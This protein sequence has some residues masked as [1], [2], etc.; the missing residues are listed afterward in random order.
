[1]CGSSLGRLSRSG[2]VPG[3]ILLAP[4]ELKLYRVLTCFHPPQGASVRLVKYFL[5]V[6][7]AGLAATAC[8]DPTGAPSRLSPHSASLVK[9][10]HRPT[11]YP[12]SRK[13]RDA[14]FRPATGSAGSA[15][16]SVRSMLGRSG[17]T[18]VEVTTG[19]F[20]A[21]A[22]GTLS[23]VQVKGYDPRGVQLFTSTNNGLTVSTASFPYSNL[24]RGGQVQVK[25]NVRDVTGSR[26]DVVTV[27]DVVHMRPDLAAL[28][29]DGPASALMGVPVNFTASIMER[30]GDLGARASCV[31]YADGAAVD[32]AD[33]IWVDAGGVVACAMSHIFTTTG[34]HA[35]EVRVE[36]VRPGDYDDANNRAAASIQ[37]VQPSEFRAFS[38]QATSLIE[39]SRSRYVSTLTTL[40]GIVETWDQTNASQGPHQ[41]ASMTGLIEHKLVFPV[42]MHGEMA[43][44]GATINTL[45]ETL[46]TSQPAYWYPVEWG[47][48]CGT[49]FGPSTDLYICTFDSG[50]LAGTSTI[51]YD[52]WGADVRYHSVSYVTYWDP[53][54]ANNLCERYIVNDYPQIGPLFTFGQDFQARLSIQGAADATPATAMATVVLSPLIFDYDYADPGCSTTP[55]SMPCYETHVHSTGVSGYT[56]SGTWPPYTP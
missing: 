39:N 19:T 36:N 21:S 26:T 4:P 7:C 16:I 29:I 32:H 56:D 6:I 54:C 34:T 41:Y 45:D 46:A 22:P 20:D 38:F 1:M 5:V 49:S 13:Y 3:A 12:N 11:T 10:D 52:W 25:A 43:T 30:N 48:S 44:N 9:S 51:Q 2:S 24:T 53:T 18:E 17:K 40:D 8:T 14:G 47:A 33:G 55:A 23:S 37:I 42:T 50:Y 31:L 35:L 15:T 28:R 27:T